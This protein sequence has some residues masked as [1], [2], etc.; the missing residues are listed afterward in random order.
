MLNRDNSDDMFER[1]QETQKK[2]FTFAEVKEIVNEDEDSQKGQ[3]L[4]QVRNPSP[5]RASGHNQQDND[6]E[7][8]NFSELNNTD[9]IE[10]GSEF[11][12]YGKGGKR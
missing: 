6:G 7:W 10:A 9:Q 12:S 1:A 5:I 8:D 3:N 4:K 2:G 11:G